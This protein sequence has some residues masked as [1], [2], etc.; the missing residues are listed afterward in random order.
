MKKIYSC[1][2]VTRLLAICI[3][4]TAGSISASASGFVFDMVN[5]PGQATASIQVTVSQEDSDTLRFTLD[6]LDPVIYGDLRGLFFHIN[7]SF[8]DPT[9]LTFTFVA[10]VENDANA[11]SANDLGFAPLDPIMPFSYGVNNIT[12][13]GSNSNN[14][15][16]VTNHIGGFDIGLE[17]GSQGASQ[18]DIKSFTFDISKAGGLD[19]M[20]FMPINMDH[21]MAARVMSLRGSNG[22]SSKLTCC[23]TT[24]PEPSSTMG[25]LA[26][27][28]G[29][30]LW[31]RRMSS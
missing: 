27:A 2:I 9:D 6:Q 1:S 16:G 24:V 4:W 7:D 11:L 31:R 8:I 25:L 18:N 13:A 15:Q 19:Q 22:G 30:L 10:A 3:V 14:L 21:F 17:I 23:T 29:G 20:T 28:V 12:S 5:Y 26:F